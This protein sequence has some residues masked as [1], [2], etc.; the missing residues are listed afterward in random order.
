MSDVTDYKDLLIRYMA[1]SA[2]FAENIPDDVIEES[3]GATEAL[4]EMTQ[5]A[6]EALLL[7]MRELQ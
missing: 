7:R 4:L 1:A 2:N 3:D 6:I 5:I